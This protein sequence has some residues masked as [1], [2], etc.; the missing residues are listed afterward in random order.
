MKI[1]N[2]ELKQIGQILI[3]ASE[4]KPLQYHIDGS[5]NP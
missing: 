5:D 2:E 1:S 3:A 4:G